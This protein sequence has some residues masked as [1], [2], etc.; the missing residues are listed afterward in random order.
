[1][2]P[3]PGRPIAHWSWMVGVV[4][5]LCVAT[6]FGLWP[7]AMQP[8]EDKTLDLRFGLRQA[9]PT[10]PRIVLIVC[11]D[12]SVSALGRWPW[13]RA[14][15]A[16]MTEILTNA[17]AHAIAFDIVFSAPSSE[18][19]ARFL[20]AMVG[21]ERAVLPI[22]VELVPPGQE[23]APNAAQIQGQ[24][25]LANTL[26]TAGLPWKTDSE[27]LLRTGRVFMPEADLAMAASG[28]GH[29]A[30]NR[31]PDGVIRRV[32]LIVRVQDRLLPALSLRVAMETFGVSPDH[33][34]IVPGRHVE[35][36]GI[37]GDAD[38]LVR[39]P[40]DAHGQMVIN[41][42]GIWTETF[43]P[44][45]GFSQVLAL[46]T[47][48]DGRRE[49]ETRF[50]SATVLILTTATGFDLKAVPLGEA[51]PGGLV[52]AQ[53]LNTILTERWVRQPA[54]IGTFL[55]VALMGCM[56]AL[57]V[58]TP[59]WIYA[60]LRVVGA[61]LFY[62]SV[63]V[64]LF[65][66]GGY[67]LPI[68]APMLAF[69]VAVVVVPVYER[70]TVRAQLTSL[71]RQM[72]ET[73][74]A[75][76]AGRARLE[77]HDLAFDGAI[78]E[79]RALR[80]A[81]TGSTSHVRELETRLTALDDALHK[82]HTERDR[83]VGQVEEL[84]RHY[85]DLRPVPLSPAQSSLE[86]DAA[87]AECAAHGIITG[88]RRMIE[89]FQMVK[90]VAATASPVLLTG[91]T[92]TGKELLARAIHALSPRAGGPFIAVNMAAIT[93]TLAESELFGH[94]RG[95]FTGAHADKKGRFEQADR[96]T[97]FMDEIGELSGELQAK[98]LRV[99]QSGEVDR[100][101]GTTP[102]RVDVRIVTA[103]NRNLEEEV[104]ATRFREDLYYRLNVVP[105]TL[106]PLRE[107]PADVERLAQHFL[108]H[109][110]AQAGKPMTGFSARALETLRRQKWRGNVRDLRN[111][112]ERA[113]VFADGQV[114]SETDLNLT[115]SLP[116]DGRES[117]AGISGLDLSGDGV[118]LDVMREMQF[119]IDAVAQR[120]GTSRGT[121][122]SRFKGICF[123]AIVA[124][125]GRMTEAAEEVAGVKDDRVESKIRAYYNNLLEAAQAFPNADLAVLECRRR[126]K[127]LPQRYFPSVEQIIRRTFA[128]PM[129]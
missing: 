8:W 113:V 24:A 19:N 10:D 102:R 21:A 56:G 69:L 58:S 2:M 46:A 47:T 86:Q 126:F 39:I 75:L 67:V 95:A 38:R 42:A 5:G 55:V 85:R 109:F 91:E 82:A 112:I 114:L 4:C 129:S 48:P 49:L 120:L 28:L 78:D 57:A 30:A 3:A 7:G 98:L 13:D 100:V 128:T 110:A 105:L 73:D 74:S 99:L 65:N 53:A 71:E 103:T 81:M 1:M 96:G 90:K 37:E 26:A 68:I 83:L 64:M 101:G 84:E 87:M 11:D 44:Q 23:T 34:S 60:L 17:G 14:V 72:R 92:G 6:L 15:H 50:K 118:F 54:T 117:L 35:L 70:T 63:A 123:Q 51:A 97:L 33:V 36:R 20:K 115:V 80:E 18:S 41:Y 119:E 40:I 31:D 62:V 124:H 107:R 125:E 88:D 93:A 59:A 79:A 12:T 25:M 9:M 122:A 106:P 16:L 77:A 45:Y 116:R 111:A 104:A 108:T 52:H 32:P 66:A 121:V 43:L 61:G 89:V 76:A 22:G 29:I 127:N 27:D 94:Q